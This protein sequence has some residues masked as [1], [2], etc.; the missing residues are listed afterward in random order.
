[1][2]RKEKLDFLKAEAKKLEKAIILAEK[3][4]LPRL[5][6]DRKIFE[7]MNAEIIKLEF[8]EE[9]QKNGK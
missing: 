9:E 4:F 1:M 2:E 7:E 3:T 8:E 5:E 6:I